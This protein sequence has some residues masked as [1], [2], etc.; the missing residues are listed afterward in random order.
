MRSLLVLL[1]TFSPVVQS[2][3]IKVLTSVRSDHKVVHLSQPLIPWNTRTQVDK[4]L[5]CSGRFIHVHSHQV[6]LSL[7]RQYLNLTFELEIAF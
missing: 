7:F 3:D 2:E 4:S 1:L 5:I 6:Q